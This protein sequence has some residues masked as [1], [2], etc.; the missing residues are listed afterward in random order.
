MCQ[1]Y[2]CVV[3]NRLSNL[4]LALSDLH[5][6]QSKLAKL[7]GS[8]EGQSKLVALSHLYKGQS[9]LEILLSL[10]LSDLCKG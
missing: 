10:A 5:K 2:M 7:S 3:Y 9:A 8:H 4:I 1:I 6:G